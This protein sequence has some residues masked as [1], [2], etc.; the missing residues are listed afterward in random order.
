MASETALR[1]NCG[2]GASNLE[3]IVIQEVAFTRAQ[4]G[5]Y[6]ALRAR[7]RNLRGR[8]RRARASEDAA[9][10]AAGD[11]AGNS[12]GVDGL[13]CTPVGVRIR[14]AIIGEVFGDAVNVFGMKGH[15]SKTVWRRDD[16][17]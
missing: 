5:E 10:T 2:A 8:E 17:V 9:P 15:L 7:E 3:Q 11:D 4:L 16:R 13:K 14:C 6:C 12:V 1:A